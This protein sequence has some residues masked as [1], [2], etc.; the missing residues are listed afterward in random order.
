M[1]TFDTPEPISVSLTLVAGD[2]RISASDRN[3]TVV[4]VTPTDS[5]NDSDVKVA[6]QTRVEYSNGALLIKAPKP[7]YRAF[8]FRNSGSID[9]A[10]ELPSDSQVDGEASVGDFSSDGRLGESRFVTGVGNL[11]LDHTGPLQLKTGTGTVSV[12]ST[13][14]RTDITGAGDVRIRK[15]DGPA[16]IK[17]LNGDTWVGEITGDLRCN[18]A[19][20][21]ITVDSAQ[22]T[23]AAKTANG[24]VRIGE[25]V[26]GSVV[27]STSYGELE[28]GIREGTAALL[29][30]GTKFGNVR[31]SLTASGGPESSDKSVEVRAR[32]SFGD[33]VIRRS[34]P[35]LYQDND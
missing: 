35:S 1:S 31:N 4:V 12:G 33:I 30:V 28:V 9:V 2:V 23:V 19:N 15:I 29:D 3:D 20:G 26:R 27:L 25:I 32:T 5:S 17:N 34:N 7:R 22:A 14:G 24:D 16:V 11:R 18:A 21:D 13:S 6:E 8:S 10:I